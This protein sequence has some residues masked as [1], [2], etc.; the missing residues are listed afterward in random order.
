MVLLSVRII[1]L[2]LRTCPVVSVGR[3]VYHTEVVHCQLMCLTVGYCVSGFVF[4]Y[5]IL[6]VCFNLYP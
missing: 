5:I 1:V 6:R 3:C 2:L 4:N